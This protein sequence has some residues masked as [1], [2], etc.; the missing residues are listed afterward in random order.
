MANNRC[1]IVFK[2]LSYSVS[3][4]DKNKQEGGPF[5]KK[6][7]MKKSILKNVNGVFRSGRL[8]AIMGA[9]GAG[10]SNVIHV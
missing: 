7:M 5:A 3:V 4:P 8:T 10:K 1:D 2:N 6:A 9:S